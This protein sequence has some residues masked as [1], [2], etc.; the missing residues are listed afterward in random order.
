MGH[1]VRGHRHRAITAWSF[2]RIPPC[3]RWGSFDKS[4]DLPRFVE[5]VRSFHFG[6]LLSNAE[7]LGISTLEFLATG[8]PRDRDGRWRNCRHD[9]E[10]RWSPHA[11]RADDRAPRE[12]A[13]RRAGDSGRAM[14][15]CVRQPHRRE[16]S[17]LGSRGARLLALLETDILSPPTPEPELLR[18]PVR[19][20]PHRAS[21]VSS[22]PA[23]VEA[24][25]HRLAA[26]RSHDCSL[27]PS[28]ASSSS[29]CRA[30]R[31]GAFTRSGAA[32]AGRSRGRWRFH[33]APASRPMR[34]VG[35]TV[36][37]R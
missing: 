35:T 37:T 16:R 25:L 17:E 29:A 32:S 23:S 27:A 1:S 28:P 11:D 9:P 2:R 12:R 22:C 18:G 36:R 19:D 33:V 7:A 31:Y 20:G 10:G 5:V 6:C 4:R 26:T 3:E 14:H 13:R 21:A 15:E 34:S 24:D 30:R 8:R